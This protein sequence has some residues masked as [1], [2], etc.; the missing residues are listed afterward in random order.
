[1]SSDAS[2]DLVVPLSYLDSLETAIEMATGAEAL[3]Y[4]HV[5]MGETAGW[6]VPMALSAVAERTDD[7]G[8]ADEVLSPYSRSPATLGQTAVTLQDLSDG[9]FRLRLGTSSP[10]LAE[11]WHGDEFDRPLRRL[12]EAV[13]IV[14]Q[15]QSGDRL[16]YDGECYDPGG[17][18]L[19]C[20]PPDPPAPVDVACFGPTAT[21]LAGRFADG[22]VPMFLPYEAL[23]E[24]IDDLQRGAEMAGRSVEDLRVVPVVQCCAI[25]DAERAREY[26]RT[27]IAFTVAVYGPFYY[28]AI[29]NAGW[30]DEAGEIRRLWRDGDHEA[31]TAA[32][33]ADLV[34]E[35]AGAGTPATVRE[36]VDRF[37]SIDGVDAVGIAFFNGLGADERERTMRALAPG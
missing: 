5:S 2:R 7:V 32:V 18:A 3:G 8:I 1:M 19:E 35:L 26:A 22:W 12:R 17:L 33:P 24:R 10:A 4:D 6:N 9:R 21:E 34:T 14:R 23:V 29:S 16:D 11:R 27:E 20:P 28:R 25:D 15:V 30:A 13:E 31:A 37:A 36:Q